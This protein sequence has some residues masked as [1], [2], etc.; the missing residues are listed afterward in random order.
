MLDMTASPTVARPGHDA[1][2]D[3]VA[4]LERL[5]SGASRA[6]RLTHL[7]RIPARLVS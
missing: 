1:G 4:L 3:A 6:D 5:A 2:V 7:E